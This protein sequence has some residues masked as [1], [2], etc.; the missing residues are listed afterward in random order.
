MEPLA[1]GGQQG[2][3]VG[4]VEASLV[5][6]RTI[7]SFVIF[8]WARGRPAWTKPND[9]GENVNL[10]KK[11]VGVAATVGLVGS[12]FAMAAPSASAVTIGSCS[13][14]QFVGKIVPPLAS[15]GAPTATVIGAKT[16][17]TGTRAWGV[18]F[19]FMQT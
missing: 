15:G 8:G 13:G 11:V 19:S 12:M 4:R 3:T 9:R 14:I 2:G 16:A 5:S 18:G 1:P 10:K 17:K 6:R 7:S